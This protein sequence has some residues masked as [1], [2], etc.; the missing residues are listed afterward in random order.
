MSGATDS[1]ET[2]LAGQH[3]D[4][5]QVVAAGLSE[6]SLHIGDFE[7][8]QSA[9]CLCQNRGRTGGERASGGKHLQSIASIH[10][11]ECIASPAHS[12]DRIR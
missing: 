9:G 6:D 2:G 8:R 4:D 1:V 3:L 5:N 10:A 7:G 11:A 12:A